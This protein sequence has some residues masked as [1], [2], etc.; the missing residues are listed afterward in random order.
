MSSQAIIGAS[1]PVWSEGWN[2]SAASIPSNSPSS[3]I[4]CL[5]DPRSS[6]GVP[7]KTISPARSLATAASPSAAPTP[8][9]AIVLWPQPCPRPGS[10]S[11]SARIPIRGP[12]VPRPPAMPRDDGRLERPGGLLHLETGRAQDLGDPGRCLSFLERGL[13]VGVDSM[14]QVDQRVARGLDRLADAA[15]RGGGSHR[16]SPSARGRGNR[17]DAHAAGHDRCSEDRVA[18]AMNTIAS[19]KS[20]IGSWN[21][22]ST[23]SAIRNAST[24]PTHAPRRIARIHSPR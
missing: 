7:K 22:P 3:I 4:T 6:A 1:T 17:L 11:Y 15:L 18:S 9:A 23:R 8:D 16:A 2:S 19:T 13:G 20:A 24:T 12:T 5:P 14:R 21:A 10:A